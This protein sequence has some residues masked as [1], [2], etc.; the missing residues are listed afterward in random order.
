MLAPPRARV[1][2]GVLALALGTLAVDACSDSESMHDPD[3]GGGAAGAPD[4]GG[5]GAAGAPAGATCQQIRMCVLEAPCA[6][7]ACVQACAARGSPAAQT[8]FEALRACTAR[9]CATADV[10]CAC[11]EQCQAGGGCLHEA[12][13]C[14]GGAA[15][16][17]ICDALCA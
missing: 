16:D 2:A 17:D 5:G 1:A 12:D 8:A 15:A 4:G 13:V 11:G 7:D 6:D 10:N 14:L 3:G 9:T